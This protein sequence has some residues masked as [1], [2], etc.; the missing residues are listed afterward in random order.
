M[1]E[2]VERV[3]ANFGEEPM[4]GVVQFNACNPQFE[5]PPHSGRQRHDDDSGD[6]EAG[7]LDSIRPLDHVGPERVKEHQRH[8][9]EPERCQS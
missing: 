9:P 4:S 1:C 5:G 8:S 6:E 2:K 3:S 7:N